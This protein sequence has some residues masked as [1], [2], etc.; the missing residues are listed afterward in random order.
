MA[1]GLSAAGMLQSPG[2]WCRKSWR[3]RSFLAF[4]SCETV[5]PSKPPAATPFWLGARC[6]LEIPLP[7]AANDRQFRAPARPID[8]HHAHSVRAKLR[9]GRLGQSVLRAPD[10]KIMAAYAP[11]L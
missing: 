6:V 7:D 8:S 10:G 9:G 3:A 2:G 5:A 1:S 4:V 11:A